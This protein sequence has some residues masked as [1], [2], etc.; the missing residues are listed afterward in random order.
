M[1]AQFSRGLTPQDR[2]VVVGDSLALSGNRP[3]GFLTLLREAESYEELTWWSVGRS[4]DRWESVLSRFETE[5]RPLRPSIMIVMLGLN[6]IWQQA[7]GQV[8]E[9]ARTRQIWQD[10]ATTYFHNVPNGELVFCSPFLIGEKHDGSNSLDRDLSAMTDLLSEAVEQW[11]AGADAA[12]DSGAGESKGAR[13][14]HFLNL[15][16][17]ALEYLQ[18]QNPGQKPHSVLTVDGIQLNKVGQQFMAQQLADYFQLQLPAPT[19]DALR[20]VVFLQFKPE[21]GPAQVREVL[22]AFQALGRRIDVVAG[23]ESGTNNSPEGLADGFTHA[24]TL[25]F[26]STADRD[27]YLNHPIHQAFVQLALPVLQ[28]VCVLDYWAQV[29]PTTQPTRTETTQ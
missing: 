14:V 4:G 24:F 13:H 15:R 19:S 26:R 16:K 2:I 25:T 7:R 18:V 27:A 12:V 1:N 23:I 20:H 22:T 6:D 8:W 17:L 28:R 3:Y 11:N 21:A 9:V 10:L 5:V 29:H